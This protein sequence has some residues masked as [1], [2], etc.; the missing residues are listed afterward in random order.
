MMYRGFFRPLSSERQTKESERERPLQWALDLMGLGALVA[1][2]VIV[3]VLLF[4]RGIIDVVVFGGFLLSGLWV[5]GRRV[6]EGGPLLQAL[7][8]IQDGMLS[9]RAADYRHPPAQVFAGALWLAAWVAWLWFRPALLESLWFPWSRRLV[10]EDGRLLVRWS[11][12]AFKFLLIPVKAQT[13]DISA[14]W[15]LVRGFVMVVLP[16][17]VSL[18]V[19]AVYHRGLLEI[20]APMLPNSIGVKAGPEV[21]P[22]R[23]PFLG[24]IGGDPAPRDVPA[25]ITIQ[26]VKASGQTRL[27]DTRHLTVAQ[28]EALRV[29]ATH[30]GESWAQNRSIPAGFTQSAWRDTQRTL[31]EAGLL[32][33]SNGGPLAPSEP[34][35]HWL[36]ERAWE[37]EGHEIPA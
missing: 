3:E 22:M 17:I 6:F 4:G 16:V 9:W 5:L 13:H 36:T 15:L 30:P 32:T 34:F 35:A 37:R 21:K 23:L 19:R 12:P 31:T 8:A 10:I 1:L 29:L 28:W 26:V 20:L 27:S 11:I 7:H 18:P 2:L 25:G 33:K 24:W 14:G